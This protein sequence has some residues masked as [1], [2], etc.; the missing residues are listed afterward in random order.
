MRFKRVAS[1]V[2][3]MLTVLGTVEAKEINMLFMGNSFTF[4]HDL[5]QLVKQVF[6]EGQPDLTVNVERIVY[7]GQ[8]MFRHHDLYFSETMVRLNTIAIP[9]VEEKASAIE[10]MLAAG[11]S[12]AFYNTYWEKTG[13]KPVG[14]S[15][16]QKNLKSAVKNQ[17]KLSQRIKNNERVK[18][19][20][21]VLQSWKDVV[22]DVDAGYAEYAQKW[23]KLAEQEGIK[24]I[25]YV[26]A[27]HA[28]NQEP[29]TEPLELAQTEMEMKT[30]QQLTERIKPHCVV[31]VA[32]GIKNIQQ[33]GTGLKFRYVN[34]MHP[35]QTSA[36]LAA[37]MF[38]ASFFKKSTEGFTFNT[39]TETNPKGKGEGKD[40]DGGDAKVV[41]DD[42]T[43]T[44]IQKAAFEAVMAFN[45]GNGK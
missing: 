39:V 18:W 21:L 10:T 42:A 32:L 23:A 12:P 41:F 22:A 2:V 45:A 27:P 9:E 30:I 4:R 34:D 24:V 33:N 6:E 26:T 44:L 14:W 13:L 3:V 5:P 8:D 25:L 37:N 19:D 38:Y 40:P 16:I 28:Q 20:Y 11:T 31:P 43:K 17:K 36:F 15:I 35:N 1:T 29:V 7:G